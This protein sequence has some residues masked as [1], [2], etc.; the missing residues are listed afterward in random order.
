MKYNVL[1]RTLGSRYTEIKASNESHREINYSIYKIVAEIR[2]EKETN[3]TFLLIRFWKSVSSAFIMYRN[4]LD[5]VSRTFN[6]Q[7]Q[8]KEKKN[9]PVF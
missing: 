4:I 7:I 8:N 6:V 3:W 2:I 9:L 5:K 1:N